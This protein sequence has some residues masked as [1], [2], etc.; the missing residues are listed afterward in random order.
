MNALFK[1][2]GLI[3]KHGSKTIGLIAELAGEIPAAAADGKITI[4][5]LISIATTTAKRLGYDV[6]E[7]GIDLTRK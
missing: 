5:E 7:Q 2:I 4:S 3:R 1:A 6:D